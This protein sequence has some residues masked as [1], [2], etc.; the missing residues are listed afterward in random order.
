MR[1]GEREIYL[2][3]S[4]GYQGVLVHKLAAELPMDI[5]PLNIAHREIEYDL[6]Q[7]IEKKIETRATSLLGK[8]LSPNESKSQGLVGRELMGKCL[9]QSRQNKMRFAIRQR[10]GR[11]KHQRRIVTKG[12]DDASPVRIH[13]TQLR[14]VCVVPQHMIIL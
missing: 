3:L 2:L 1:Y 10:R 8:I 9:W 12:K 6:A 13:G 4:A 5:W 11:L 14:F 7:T